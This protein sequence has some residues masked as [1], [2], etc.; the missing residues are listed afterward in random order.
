MEKLNFPDYEF[1]IIRTSDNKLMIF[2]NLRKK[3]IL[4]TPEE[5]VRQNIIRFLVSDRRFPPS[6]ISVESGLKVNR[7]SRRYDVL[8]F[9]REGNPLVLIECKAPNVT[10]NQE[11]FNQITA[12]N[13]T[14]HAKYF[15]VSNGK[16]HFF[17]SYDQNLKKFLF[18][19]DIPFFENL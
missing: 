8:I 12:Y 1:R 13:L 4:L 10:V 2:D 16:K 18:L 17:A 5:W 15:L 3:E 19:D 6:L 9:N 7:L 11:T 14:V